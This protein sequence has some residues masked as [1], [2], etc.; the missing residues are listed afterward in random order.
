MSKVYMVA[1]CRNLAVSLPSLLV[2]PID[3]ETQEALSQLMVDAYR[4]TADWEDGDDESVALTEIRSIQTGDY[5]PFLDYASGVIR[6]DSGEP[7]S[8]LF[9][10]LFENR[11]T[12]IFAFTAKAHIR[13]GHAATLIRNAAK[14]LLVEGYEQIALFVSPENPAI[15]LYQ[16]LGFTPK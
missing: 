8:A 4:G 11:P 15:R 3:F 14:K 2:D 7:V 6:A 13:K 16:G 1:K 9:V 5:G 12:I 10:T